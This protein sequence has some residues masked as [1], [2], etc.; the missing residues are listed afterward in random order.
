MF[1]REVTGYDADG[2]DGVRVHFADGREAEADV[3]VGADGVNSAVRRA[4]PARGPG[5]G[6]TGGRCIYGKTPLLPAA[7][8]IGC[9]PRY[10]GGFTAVIGGQARHGDRAGPVSGTALSRCPGCGVVSRRGLSDVG[11]DPRPQA[12]PGLGRTC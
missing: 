7:T 12:L 5:P 3:L 1:G 10:G 9:L 11:P 8:R 4:V 2:P 6:N